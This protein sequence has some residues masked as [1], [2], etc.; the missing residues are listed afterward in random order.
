MWPGISIGKNGF[1]LFTCSVLN[2]LVYLLC[3]EQAHVIN[4]IHCHTYVL[5]DHLVFSG[6][7]KKILPV[8][9]NANY[10]L[11]RMK[12]SDLFIFFRCFI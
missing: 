6:L 7:N 5:V 2:R 8:S 4:S 12:G 1:V 10:G 11:F 9:L 3:V